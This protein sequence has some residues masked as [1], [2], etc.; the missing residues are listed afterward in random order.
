M[1]RHIAYKRVSTTHQ[2]TIRQFHNTQVV[3]DEIFEDKL[4]GKDTKRPEFLHCLESLKKGDTLHVWEISRMSR[5]LDDLRKNVFLLMD[6]G[7]TV[8]FHKEGLEFCGDRDNIKFAMDK[9]QLNMYGSVGELERELI[10][11]RVKEGLAV[12]VANGVK[13]GGAATKRKLAYEKNY[14]KLKERDNEHKEF[15]VVSR[16]NGLSFRE[17]ADKM[18]SLG[19][20][21]PRGCVMTAATVQRMCV[22]LG[23]L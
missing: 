9:F 5:N 23:I 13:L 22:K 17:I 1:G 16:K 18:N 11:S 20:K 19:F 3:F 7:V 2:E 8:K 4:S 12:A 14:L 10:R 21:S 15:L 6:K